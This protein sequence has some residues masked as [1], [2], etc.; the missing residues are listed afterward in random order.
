MAVAAGGRHTV[1]VCSDGSV[2]SFGLGSHGQL[3]YGGTE[4]RRTPTRMALLP[5]L[6]GPVRQVAA[7]ESHTGIVTDTGD[8]IMCGFGFYGQLGL[9]DDDSQTTPTLVP[10]TEFDDEAVLMVACAGNKTVVATEGGAVYTFGSVWVDENDNEDDDENDHGEENEEENLVP[11]RVP[12]AAFNGERIVMVATGDWHTV[13][14]SEAGLVFTWGLGEDGQLGHNNEE[15]QLAPQQVEPGRF[16]HGGRVVFVAAMRCQTV[17]VT[18]EGRLYTWGL[19]E[20]GQLGHGDNFNR[21]VPTQVGGFGVSE[22]DGVIMAAC[23]AL[24]TLVVTE[25]GGLW[26]S[27]FEVHG[28]FGFNDERNR[29]VFERVRDTM[30]PAFSGA[31][32]VAAAAGGLH[33]AALTEDG[34][35]WTWGNG[36]HGCLGHGDEERR[37]APTRVP[38]D[39]FGAM[40]IGCCH[41]LPRKHA[42]AFAMGT[43]GRLGATSNVRSLGGK[44]ELLRMI[45][46][47]CATVLPGLA[48]GMEGLMRL[49][50]G[51]H[52]W[53]Q[54]MAAAGQ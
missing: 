5:P 53:K 44:V 27:G 32:V 47:W 34:T 10:R 38:Q 18:P 13:A 41:L 48:G 33:S 52:A 42:V 8:L 45:V 54:R 40:R 37:F 22:G 51:F 17:A 3:G 35:L 43:H 25:D 30:D 29:Y 14:L 39:S 1:A 36:W 2:F 24:H 11:R 16:G 15:V 26:G 12:A 46:W 50:G 20:H 23:G 9:G 21:L 6:S 4:K 19:G 49:C 28:Q 31:R 7:G